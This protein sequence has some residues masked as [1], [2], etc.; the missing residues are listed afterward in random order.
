MDIP[1]SMAG[2]LAAWNNG[3]GIS[4]EDWVGCEGNFRLAVGYISLF[5]PQFVT[6]EDYLLVKGFT[7][8]NLR[9]FES[10]KGA[11]A[12]SVEWVLNHVHLGSIQHLEC[13][14]ISSD[15]LVLLGNTLKEIYQAKLNWQFPERPCIVEFYQPE[16]PDDFV[17][18]QLSFW[19]KKHNEPTD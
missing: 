5:W 2:E 14:D 17:G 13:P 15:K 6:F 16:D 3:K 12:K 7:V 1:D 8:E 4:L 10:Q 9:G 19:Q 11:T 18:Y